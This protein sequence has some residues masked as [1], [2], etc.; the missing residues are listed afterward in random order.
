M[1]TF[2]IYG[3]Y[4]GLI[5][6][7]ESMEF[8]WNLRNLWDLFTTYGVYGSHLGFMGFVWDL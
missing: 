6:F 5:G 3:I 8:I 2:G 4:Y 7:T 1:D